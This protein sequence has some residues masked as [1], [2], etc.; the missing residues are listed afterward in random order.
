[1]T[2]YIDRILDVASHEGYPYHH[3]YNSLLEKIYMQKDVEISSI[4]YSVLNH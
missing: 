4:L 2:T 1:M 3:V